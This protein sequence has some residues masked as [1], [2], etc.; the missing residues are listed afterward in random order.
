M[1]LGRPRSSISRDCS[2]LLLL[3]APP[4]PPGQWL[5]AA[6]WDEAGLAERRAPT[7][8]ELDDAIP[9]RPLLALHYPYHR[10]LANS[11]A[12]EAAGEAHP[13]DAACG[14]GPRWRLGSEAK[15]FTS[16]CR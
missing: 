6:D 7:R 12:L 11:R 16:P 8:Q 9:D 2:A 10:A 13:R 15:R 4:P 14:E 1:R 5:I 3:P